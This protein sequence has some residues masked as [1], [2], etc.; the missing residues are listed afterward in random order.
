M[1]MKIIIKAKPNAREEIVEKLDDSHFVISVKE[2]PIKGKAN[3]AI[4]RALAK[5]FGVESSK[6]NIVSGHASRQKI[7]RIDTHRNE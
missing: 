5:Y 7:I 3:L 4:I 6:V 1:F 2:Q